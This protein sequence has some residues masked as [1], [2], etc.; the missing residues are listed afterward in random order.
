[1]SQTILHTDVVI[2]GG[3]LVGATFALDLARHGVRCIIVDK[4]NP[5]LFTTD[6]R[7]T[8]VSYGNRLYFE[9]LGVWE[10]LSPQA[11][12]IQDIKFFEADSPWGIFYHKKD[13]PWAEAL[14]YMVDN[15]LIRKT[16]KSLVQSHE[17]I[18]WISGKT[19]DRSIQKPAGVDV[20]LDDETMISAK[21]LVGA[22]GRNSLVRDQMH[23]KTYDWSYPQHAIV[24]Q[25]TH[26]ED[27][28]QLAYE[29]FFPEGPLA[30]L[31]ML[32]KD[33][34]PRSAVIW[35]RSVESAQELMAKD[36]SQFIQ[37][38]SSIFPYYHDLALSSKRQCYP[39]SAKI[40][41]NVV[42]QRS[43]IIG[44]AAHVVHP[45][46]GQGV[47]VGWRDAKELAA[48]LARVHNLGID[49]GMQTHL[50]DYERSRMKDTLGV[51]AMTDGLTRLFSNNSRILYWMRNTGLG[52]TNRITPLK[53]FFMRKAMGL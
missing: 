50:K 15:Q 29:L 49:L 22:E 12:S 14:A 37:E 23:V 35:M 34:K 17:N 41:K 43:V 42:G 20:T 9:E 18:T 6:E 32:E 21:L 52:I 13:I 38:L 10:H 40:A 53:R 19:M 39:I 1:M 7:V 46:A 2:I 47:N 30:V 48:T 45:V 27:H 44:D 8:A 51:L 36:E 4:E 11:S 25:I 16:L 26:A 31:P 33:G 3:G 5:D 28:K 24:F